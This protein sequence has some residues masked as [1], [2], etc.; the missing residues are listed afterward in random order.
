MSVFIGML[1]D[2][3]PMASNLQNKNNEV[4]KVLDYTVGEY[5][6]NLSEINDELFLTSA[7]GGWLD[8]WGKDYGVI[9][10]IDESDDDFRERIIFEKLEYLTAHNLQ[11]IYGVRLFSAFDGFNPVEND[12]TSDNPY[13][14]DWFM[15]VAP[16]ETQN[17][18]NNK[19]V[20]GTTVMWYNGEELDYIIQYSTNAKLLKNYLDL[21]NADNLTNY[22]WVVSLKS[23][24][25][26][27][28]LVTKAQKLFY[29]QTNLTDVKLTLPKATDCYMMLSKCNSLSSVELE[30]PNCRMAQSMFS[31]CTSLTSITLKLPK[32]YKA[33]NVFK[34]CTALTNITLKL[35]KARYAWSVFNGCTALTSADI[36]F[37]ESNV[38][39][40]KLFDGCTALKNVKLNL[41]NYYQNYGHQDF[42]HNCSNIETIDVTLPESKVSGFKTYINGLNLT[43]LTTLIING[44]EVDLS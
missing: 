24:K 1:C 39:I 2:M 27:L 26:T 13:L 11:N 37:G 41:S 33:W 18:L 5:M 15:G 31:Q 19:F 3:L 30:V 44:E 22:L 35:P 17:I 12:L 42:F 36:D 14:T 38:D 43:H 29:Q 21:Y 23:V 7:T 32:A 10:K 20:L 9:R 25:L 28:P 4:R 16:E 6:D 40:M 34:G 8:A